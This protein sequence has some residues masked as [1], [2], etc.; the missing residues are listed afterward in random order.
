MCGFTTKMQRICVSLC[1]SLACGKQF[2]RKSARKVQP[3]A[4]SLWQVAWIE[5][6]TGKILAHGCAMAGGER[7][8]SQ[9]VKKR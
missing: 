2:E 6:N 9:A 7:L 5:V 8:K 4:G 1:G 3:E